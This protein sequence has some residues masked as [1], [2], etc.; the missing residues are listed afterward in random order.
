MA[1][2]KREWAQCELKESPGAELWVVVRHRRG[3]FRVP[4][5]ASIAT[6]LEGVQ[7][8]WSGAHRV[9]HEG[10]SRVQISA[11]EY[12]ELRM[13]AAECPPGIADAIRRDDFD[14]Y[15]A[16]KGLRPYHNKG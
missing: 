6:V 16:Q 13:L 14:G 15:L 10:T 5:D 9:S 12:A 3:W 11:Q 8:G 1:R 2:S 4:A 7:A